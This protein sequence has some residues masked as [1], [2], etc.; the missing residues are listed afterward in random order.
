[1]P[2]LPYPQPQLADD[3]VTL[4]AWELTD[5]RCVEEASWNPRIPSGTTVPAEFS[6]DEGRAFIE[7]QWSRQEN[8]EGLAL[9]IA[10]RVSNDAVGQMALLFRERPGVAGIG[11][12]VIERA[13]NRGF[14][15]RAVR[16]LSRWA[17]E[18]AGLARIEALVEPDNTASQR[19]LEGAGFE[20]E[21]LLR[22]YLSVGSVRAD[23]FMYSLVS[24]DVQ[25]PCA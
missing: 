10:D 25:R 9:A 4:R 7:R 13:R 12:W 1:M 5:L 20:R 14:A 8:G 3:R 15:R 18:E 21:G 17:L 16:L 2:K 6:V 11:Y 24:E 19:V 23:A 22:S